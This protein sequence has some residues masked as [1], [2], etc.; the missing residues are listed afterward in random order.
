MKFQGIGTLDGVVEEIE[1]DASSKMEAQRE[2]ASLGYR[3]ITIVEKASFFSKKSVSS[4]ELSIT[5]RQLAS[6]ATAG[7]TFLKSLSDVAAVTQNK[8]LQ[9]ALL[10]VRSKVEMGM[11]IPSAFGQHKIFS[12]VII[13]LLRVGDESGEMETVLNELANYLEQITDIE[14]GVNSAL[15]YPKIISGV[16]VLAGFFLVTYVLPQFRSFYT[17]MKIEM[18]FMT[19]M[20][21]AMSDFINNDWIIAVPGICAILYF[22][23]NLPR[24][25]PMFY[26]NMI[27][28]APIIKSIMT[29][30]Y[31]FR[32]C[33]TLQ[34]LTQANVNIIEAMNLVRDTLDN[35]LYVEVLDK[36]IPL[37]RIGEGIAS[38]MRMNDPD[39]RFDIMAMA[40]LATGEET[41]NIPEL[42]ATASRHYQ[43]VLK[44]EI[45][46]FGKRLEPILL[47][48]IAIFVFILVA[49]VY[50]PIF[51]MS[52][53]AGAK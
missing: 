30:M 25:A 52:Q 39:N 16:M 24:F 32:F 8:I 18:P 13:N 22:I 43:K 27:I 10:D 17:N 34:I 47:F 21:Y 1:I 4:K 53:M 19:K 20:L 35:H 46:N 11:S 15:M 41:N 36:T 42:M 31:M 12:P 5:F 7:E 37:I 40:F 28:S 45:E 23:K 33:K 50:L 49:S 29:N 26:D 14:D 44:M 48:V 38:S 3:D 51:R 2:M 6:F 9:E